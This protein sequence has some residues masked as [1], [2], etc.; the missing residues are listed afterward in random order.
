MLEL[1][2]NLAPL[3]IASAALPLQ[4]II[5]LQLVRSST[6]AAFAW[7]AGMTTVRLLQGFLFAVVFSASEKR[8][9]PNSPR[10]LLAGLLLILALLLYVK[11]LRSLLGA[12]DEDAPPPRWLTKAGSMSPL[13]AFAAG[14]GF[15]IVSVKFLVFTLG[16]ISAITE[17]HRDARL[18]ALTFIS[19]VALAEIAPLTILA[20]AAISSSQSV[21]ILD[22]FS[23]W[24]RRNNRVITVLIGVVF[25]TWF[26][27]KALKQLNVI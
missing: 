5:T 26:L 3:I 18:S 23:A 8:S 14:A 2:G 20:L 10:F 13:A 27:L 7:V 16:A 19:F 12:E 25:G 15:M 24:L 4:T 17:A 1:W 6:R 22:A 9:A 21:A 11:A